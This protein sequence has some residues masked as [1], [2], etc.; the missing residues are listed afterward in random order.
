[1]KHLSLLTGLDLSLSLS[2]SHLSITIFTLMY[3][4]EISGLK[5][6]LDTPQ[7]FKRHYECTKLLYKKKY[8]LW[9]ES[10]AAKNRQQP[11]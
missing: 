4:N 11:F 8:G 10:S 1:M 6:S 3:F 7:S 2:L 9:D 5:H